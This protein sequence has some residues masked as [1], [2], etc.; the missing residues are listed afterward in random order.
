MRRPD[1]GGEPRRRGPLEWCAANRCLLVGG[2]TL[3]F[4]A[5]YWGIGEYVLR[6]HDVAP[7][8]DFAF[9][10]TFQRLVGVFAGL[11]AV[12]MLACVLLR[13]RAPE[14]R[15]LVHATIQLYGIGHATGA[16][17]VG[18]VTSPHGFI[19]LGGVAVALV[20]FDRKAVV[21]GIVSGVLV[22]AVGSVLIATGTMRYAPLLAAAP[23]V[24]G[25]VSGFWLRQ[26]TVVEVSVGV[27]VIFLFGY[28]VTRL[29]DR[30]A[31]LLVMSITDA[32]TG[33]ANRRHFITLFERE[34]E[35]A[36]RYKT[37]LSCVL[38]DLDHF[39][40][41]NDK[42]GHM[43]GDRVL[44][45]AA[46]V[47]KS[48]LRAHD[49]LARWGGEEFVVLLPQ[50]DLPGAEAMAERCRRALEEA[51][52]PL[53]DGRTVRVTT[54]LGVACHPFPAAE[55]GDDLLLRADTALYEAKESG[56]NRSVSLPPPAPPS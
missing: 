17:C 45:T 53:G 39:K 26:M 33:I 48:I 36:K 3:P 23:Y 49:V 7:Y 52:I 30:E 42:Y 51:R 43:A 20:L 1:D 5:G 6:E 27:A 56:R 12:L 32:L 38:I 9:L 46:Q 16:M 14:S 44:V 41:V 34:L 37:P 40:R 29:R 21:L 4:L 10:L 13:K 55:T 25:Q 2:I 19:L 15:A 18:P 24:D 50:T 47:F 31:R 11:W 22:L 35:R 54:S 8:Y 28:L